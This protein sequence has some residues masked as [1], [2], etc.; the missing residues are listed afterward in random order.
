M[1]VT[2]G[3]HQPLGK[4]KTVAQRPLSGKDPKELAIGSKET[5]M[6]SQQV[7]PV[8]LPGTSREGSKNSPAVPLPGALSSHSFPLPFKHTSHPMS[9]H[10]SLPQ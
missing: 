5:W 7:W 3:S 8:A 1:A 6:H 10:S 2:M 4:G 9:R